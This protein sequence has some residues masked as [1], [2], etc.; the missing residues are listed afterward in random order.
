VDIYTLNNF[1]YFEIKVCRPQLHH[2]IQRWPFEQK[3]GHP[4]TKDWKDI[5]QLEGK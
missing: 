4:Y 3:D 1:S 5:L 2:L